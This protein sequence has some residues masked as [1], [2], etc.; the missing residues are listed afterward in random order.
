VITIGGK[1]LGDNQVHGGHD[2]DT[3]KKMFNCIHKPELQVA[4]IEDEVT[5]WD[6]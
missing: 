3:G 4:I 6:K 2:N 5:I 1:V